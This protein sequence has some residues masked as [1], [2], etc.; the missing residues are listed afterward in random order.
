MLVEQFLQFM[1]HILINACE[2]SYVEEAHGTLELL[3]RLDKLLR[4]YIDD[5]E[6]VCLDQEMN[7]LQDYIF[8][9][10][11]KYGNA[12]DIRIQE[13]APKYEIHIPKFSVISYVDKIIQEHKNESDVYTTYFISTEL[14]KNVILKIECKNSEEVK[15]YEYQLNKEV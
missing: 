9:M 4:Y 7:T 3:Q 6:F 13:T 1:H 12:C 15:N 8:I 2:M 11:M 5:K 14:N 10:K